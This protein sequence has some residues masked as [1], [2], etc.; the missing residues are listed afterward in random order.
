[1]RLTSIYLQSPLST[2]RLSSRTKIC[3]RKVRSMTR[4][5]VR[6]WERTVWGALPTRDAF[7]GTNFCAR[8]KSPSVDP[9]TAITTSPS[10]PPTSSQLRD[11]DG[12]E[13]G[14]RER[15][16]HDQLIPGR[17]SI[18]VTSSCFR[19]TSTAHSLNKDLGL[20]SYLNASTVVF[21]T[22][23]CWSQMEFVNLKLKI[24]LPV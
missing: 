18:I 8:I 10:S 6:T 14:Q 24:K 3:S 13:D 7:Y 17:R 12:G 21:L 4:V 19:C 9:I 16:R 20:Q 1:M 22:R 5:S 23:L 11:R 2:D 15:E